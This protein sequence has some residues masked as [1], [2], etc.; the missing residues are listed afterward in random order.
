MNRTYSD[1]DMYLECALY[2]KAHIMN[3]IYTIHMDKLFI[4]NLISMIFVCSTAVFQ[5]QLRLIMII[6]TLNKWYRHRSDQPLH[7]IL[8][9]G[10]ADISSMYGLQ[11]CSLLCSLA[12]ANSNSWYAFCMCV[13]GFG[14]GRIISLYYKLNNTIKDKVDVLNRQTTTR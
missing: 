4:Y 11:L 5:T 6:Y 7:I 8:N 2:I 10:L 3:C 13:Y 14:F 1:I 12:C 9:S